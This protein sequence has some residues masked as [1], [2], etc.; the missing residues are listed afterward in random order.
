MIEYSS[1]RRRL[2]LVAGSAFTAGGSSTSVTV[3]DPDDDVDESAAESDAFEH[4]PLAAREM[5]LRQFKSRIC[6]LLSFAQAVQFQTKEIRSVW[7]A[8]LAEDLWPGASEGTIM[9]N[10]RR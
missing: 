7:K 4:R 10:E 8:I 5:A 3:V 6:D 9:A 1:G 2:A